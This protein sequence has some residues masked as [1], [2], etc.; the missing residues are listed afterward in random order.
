MYVY[1]TG[2]NILFNPEGFENAQNQNCKLRNLENW[3]QAYA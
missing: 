1:T 2:L 3:A